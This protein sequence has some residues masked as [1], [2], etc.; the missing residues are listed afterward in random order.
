MNDTKAPTLGTEGFH[1]MAH[2]D[3][4]KRL[5]LDKLQ[6][7]VPLTLGA[8]VCLATYI[9]PEKTG[10]GIIRPDT[11][12][13]E[14]IYQGKLG[15]VIALGPIAF[16]DG[17]DADFGGVVPKLHDWV[18]FS[19]QHGSAFSLMGVHCRFMDDVLV[20]AIVDNP[21]SVY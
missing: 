18:V 15:L 10:G 4:P 8:K 3:D 12:V 5:I 17:K 19:S 7:V 20:Q 16:K 2:K 14:D 9:R 11:N 21:D 13:R 1:K 6:G